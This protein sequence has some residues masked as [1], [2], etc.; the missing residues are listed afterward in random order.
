[1]VANRCKS[2]YHIKLL[3]EFFFSA[4]NR[5]ISTF[6]MLLNMYANHEFHSL[7]AQPPLVKNTTN[8]FPLKRAAN[9]SQYVLGRTFFQ[10]AYVIADFERNNFSVSQVRFETGARSS[11]QDITPPGQPTPMPKPK[12]KSPTGAIVGAVVGVVAALAIAALIAW[13]LIRR[14]KRRRNATKAAETVSSTTDRADS[15]MSD[16]DHVP[17][18]SPPAPNT[19]ELDSNDKRRQELEA[20]ESAPGTPNHGYYSRSPEMAKRQ[21]MQQRARS[22]L[23]ELEARQVHELPG[24]EGD[25]ANGGNPTT[26]KPLHLRTVSR[27]EIRS[28]SSLI[29]GGVTPTTA[30]GADKE[31][32]DNNSNIPIPPS[33]PISQ[34]GD[35]MSEIDL[36]GAFVQSPG[37]SFSRNKSSGERVP[38]V[39]SGSGNDDAPSSRDVSPPASARLPSH[40]SDSGEISPIGS[41]TMSPALEGKR[42]VSVDSVPIILDKP[43]SGSS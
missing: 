4:F 1:M 38:M 22:P 25:H 41:R 35:D 26:A 23:T 32:K 2:R 11:L 28:P 16:S 27:D 5:S 7:E 17:P 18:Y 39:R 20:T 30:G 6:G 14:R 15:A 37:R 40:R 19:V 3:S 29:T 33:P 8:Y 10:E 36:P 43:Q 13:C 21:E 31:D 34:P 42:T 9:E 24:S 12:S